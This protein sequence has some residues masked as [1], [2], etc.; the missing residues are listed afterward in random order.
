VNARDRK[1]P[2]PTLTQELDHWI[3]AHVRTFEFLG[4]VPELIVPDNAKTA[5]SKTC[6]YEPQSH[7]SGDGNA[8]R[9]WGISGP[10]AETAR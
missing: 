6:R 3:G 9:C 1:P 5:V 2:L 4:G 8:L 7:L 10:A